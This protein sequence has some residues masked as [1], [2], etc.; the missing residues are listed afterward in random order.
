MNLRAPVL[1]ALPQQLRLLR[2]YGYQVV[3]VSRL[4]ELSPFEDLAPDSPA[5]PHVLELLRQGHIVGYQNN[6]FQGEKAI[7]PEEFLLMAA[8]PEHLRTQ[9]RFSPREIIRESKR[10]LGVDLQDASG[11][12]LLDLAWR[13]GIDVDEAGFKDKKAVKRADAAPLLA[14]LARQTVCVS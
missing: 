6:T 7:T 8:R 4:L 11:K 2:Q 5:A 10:D 13:R 9:A 1:D 12:T 14:A 3:P